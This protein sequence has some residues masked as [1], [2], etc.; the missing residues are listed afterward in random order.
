MKNLISY[1]HD[2]FE[3]TNNLIIG[4]E[5]TLLTRIWNKEDWGKTNIVHIPNNEYIFGCFEKNSINQHYYSI[6]L[7]N[8]T[9]LII[10]IKG[11][12]FKFFYG[13]GKRKLNTYN[14]NLDT[15]N[16]LIIENE[17]EMRNISNINYI[18]Y[19]LLSFAIRPKNFFEDMPSFYYFRVFQAK[20]IND[21]IIQ[22]LKNVMEVVIY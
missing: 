11:K 20:G 12:N 17:M 2:T 10:E 5:F 16:E 15:T 8:E 21:L 19:T 6:L 22:K 7:Y 1:Y 9:E 18:N 13:E 3:T 4:F 14:D